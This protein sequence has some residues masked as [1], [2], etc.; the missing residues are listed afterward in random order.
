[1]D[2]QRVD[3]ESGRSVMKEFTLLV[4]KYWAIAMIFSLF[5]IIEGFIRG[6]YVLVFFGAV[7]TFVNILDLIKWPALKRKLFKNNLPIT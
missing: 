3:L 4:W 2:D 5:L 6:I 7:L 1:M